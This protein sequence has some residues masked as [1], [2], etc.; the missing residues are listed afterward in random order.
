[1]SHHAAKIAHL[2]IFSIKNKQG[3]R[4]GLTKLA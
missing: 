2:G 3:N 4:S 1:V